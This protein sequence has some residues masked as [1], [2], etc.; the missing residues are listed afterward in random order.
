MDRT[1]YK[2]EM[3]WFENLIFLMI[4]YLTKA[5]KDWPKKLIKSIYTLPI[6]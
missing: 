4:T 6:I 3:S 5:N 1:D 2:W